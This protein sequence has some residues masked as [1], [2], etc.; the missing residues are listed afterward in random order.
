[1]GFTK[2][3][4]AA[5]L[6]AV[7]V[8][9]CAPATAHADHTITLTFVRHAESQ[10][11]ASGLI[12]TS[13]PGPDLSPQGYQQAAAAA[14][15]LSPNAY[16]GIYASTMVRTQETAAPLSQAL[17]ESVSVLPG[18]REIEAGTYEGK[19]ETEVQDYLAAPLQWVDG[20][21]DARIPGSVD[22]NEFDARFDQAVESIYDSGELKPVAFSHS[23]AIL[24][25]VL[26]NT[27]NSD[28]SLLGEWLPNTGQAVVVGNPR[29]GWTLTEWDG[30]AVPQ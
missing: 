9:L 5:I 15:D 23:A 1:M 21:R 6:A 17:D 3:F 14:K 16:D 10:G 24:L 13:V 11:N 20:N 25:W 26:M 28:K 12:D 30:H 8:A 18:L 4:A 19:P 22:G 2:K 29:K 7:T 27:K